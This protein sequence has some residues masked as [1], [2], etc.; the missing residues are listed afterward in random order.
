ML[1]QYLLNIGAIVDVSAV[2]PDATMSEVRK[3]IEIVKGYHCICA[4]PMPFITRYTIEALKGVENTI[5][6]GVVGFPAGAE[7]THIKKA[8]AEELLGMG[9]RELDMVMNISAF[10]SKDYS[11]T[12]DDIKAVIETANGIPVKVII[13][14]AYL[15]DDEIKKASE[16]AVESGATF[17]KTGTGYGP[18]PTTVETI[19][20][21]RS[22][23]GD[24]AFIKAA[25]GVRDLDTLLAMRE[26]GCNRFGLGVR[27]AETILGDAYKRAGKEPLVFSET[28]ENEASNFVY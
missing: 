15:T 22:Q 3:M 5:V 28:T 17:V 25:G 10:K 13:E 19:R 11:Y 23:I 4:S 21:I 14:I 8:T 7:T 6:T 24:A 1:M 26:A 16:I 9:C 2:K 12:S 20:L 18:K 27:M